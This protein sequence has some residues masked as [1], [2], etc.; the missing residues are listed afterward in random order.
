MVNLR[1]V[2]DVMEDEM[3]TLVRFNDGKIK[4]CCYHSEMYY[5]EQLTFLKKHRSIKA[6]SMKGKFNFV[7]VDNND[8]IYLMRDYQEQDWQWW[9]Y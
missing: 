1:N 4:L 8:A 9:G 6:I 7:A 3:T 5:E 2:T